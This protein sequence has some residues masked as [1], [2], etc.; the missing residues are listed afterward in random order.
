MKIIQKKKGVSEVVSVVLI[1]M[2]TVAAIAVLWM[3]VIPMI[4]D[5]TTKGAVCFKANDALTIV[6][7]A[8]T[9]FALNASGNNS[10]SV[11]TSK[12]SSEANVSYA[13]IIVYYSDGSSSSVTKDVKDMAANTENRYQLDIGT[14]NA[15]AVAVAS[16]IT[17]GKTNTTCTAGPKVELLAC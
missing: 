13:Q 11:K 3:V 16:I 4:K 12:G 6:D 2:I 9:C 17:T 10:V 1:I 15:S 8:F 7:D 14:K 5:N